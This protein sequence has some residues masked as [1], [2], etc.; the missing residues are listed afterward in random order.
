MHAKEYGDND[1]YLQ[2][3]TEVVGDNGARYWFLDRD[4]GKGS[5]SRHALCVQACTHQSYFARTQR[6][7]M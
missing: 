1:E 5:C 2:W 4:G 7:H 3:E 6:C